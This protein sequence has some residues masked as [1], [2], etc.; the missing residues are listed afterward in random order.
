MN[1]IKIELKNANIEE[2][3]I[4][5]YSSKVE[6]I[7]KQLRDEYTDD[8]VGWIEWPTQYDKKEFEKIKECAKKINKNS[9]VFVVIGIGGSYLGARR[10]KTSTCYICWE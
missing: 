2:K 9:E 5:K 10:K 3:M 8:P 6:K 7:H 1:D 4:Q